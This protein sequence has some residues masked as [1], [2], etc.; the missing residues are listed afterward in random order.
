MF[1]NKG[2]RMKFTKIITLL[3]VGSLIT[4]YS[5]AKKSSKK[6][7]IKVVVEES[8]EAKTIVGVAAA[9]KKF[10]TLVTAVKAAD[11][12][13]TLNSEK[14]FTVFAPTNAAFDKLAE[15]TLATLLKAENKEM[16]TSILTYHIVLGTFNAA[17]IIEAITN[18]D[19]EFSIK[20]IQ[21][22][23]LIASLQEE[24][25]V[26]TDTKGNISTIVMTDVMA[27][28]GIIHAIDSVVMSD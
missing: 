3:L 22:S 11:L 27:S 15:G 17:T 12:V 16:L 7:K 8:P 25:V 24:K 26:L 23:I 19:G 14:S 28:N 4:A 10:S 18:N 13:E 6:K 2:T 1:L 5:C 9:D 20:T 21:G